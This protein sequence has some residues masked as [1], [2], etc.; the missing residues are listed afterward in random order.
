MNGKLQDAI[1]CV[2]II[3]GIKS[4]NASTDISRS[5]VKIIKI[6]N[7]L[8]SCVVQVLKLYDDSLRHDTKDTSVILTREQWLAFYMVPPSPP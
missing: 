2:C 7:E 1:K 5:M 8:Y 6:Q 4:F 3:D